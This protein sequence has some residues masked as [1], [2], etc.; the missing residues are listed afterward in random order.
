MVAKAYHKKIQLVSLFSLVG[1]LYCSFFLSKE[2][3]LCCFLLIVFTGVYAIPVLPKARNFRDLG[4]L[5]IILV[6]L[7]WSGITVIIPFLNLKQSLTWDV[8]MEALQRFIIVLILLIPFEI[9][10]LK[11][12]PPELN[13]LPQRYG[14][15]KSKIFGAYAVVLFFL[16]T[17]LKD[18]VT[19]LDLVSKGILFLTLGVLM[20]GTKRNQ[21]KYFS[22]FW[23]ESIPIFWLGIVYGVYLFV[24]M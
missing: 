4:G 9:R 15:T 14:V 13:T 8:Y 1:S 24:G 6:A 2:A 12:D 21:S 5:K 16:M 22:S 10:D 20:Y 23:V 18:V 3:I 19:T 11:H 7:V 17:Y